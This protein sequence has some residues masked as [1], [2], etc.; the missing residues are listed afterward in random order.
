SQRIAATTHPAGEL[1][2]IGTHGLR[3]NQH[4]VHPVAQFMHQTAR[5]FATNPFRVATGRR[6]AAVKRGGKLE[7]NQGYTRADQYGKVLVE[8]LT[9]V[10]QDSSLY[11]DTSPSQAAQATAMHQG[12]RIDHADDDSL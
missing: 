3:A 10:F 5:Q 6:D 9:F 12:V 11:L 7:G 1:R 4:C 8:T 2:V